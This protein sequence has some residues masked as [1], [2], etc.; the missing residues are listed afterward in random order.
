MII[1]LLVSIIILCLC[2]YCAYSF[3]STYRLVYQLSHPT[4]FERKLD[5]DNPLFSFR[6][7]DF[8]TRDGLTLKAIEY[9]PRGECIGSIIACHY[10]GGSKEVIL[11]YLEFLIEHGYRI[12]SYDAR[13]HG[14]SEIEKQTK[15]RLDDDARFFMDKI[16][17]MGLKGPFGIL[18]FSM[19]ATPALAALREYPEIKAAVID[20]GPLIYVENYFNYVLKIKNIINPLYKLVFNM[21]YLYYV[22]FKKMSNNTLNT[23]EHLKGYP[24][25]FIQAEKDTVIP[26]DNATKAYGIVKSEKTEFWCVKN[27]RHL[28]N[29]VL[30]GQEYKERVTAFFDKYI[31]VK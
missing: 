3:L 9:M 17:S 1:P 21:T 5:P 29:M 25:F 27:S 30:A 18:G 26:M 16:I 15:F 20:S 6:K 13:N 11:P 23:L 12:L 2:A 31:L 4:I 14:E 7:F 22:G 19:G 10:L 24:I 8:K 28:T